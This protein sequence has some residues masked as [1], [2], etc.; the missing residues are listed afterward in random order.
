MD[1]FGL[2]LTLAQHLLL[3]PLFSL[4]WLNFLFD[5]VQEPPGG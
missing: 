3:E 4:P 5:I 1:E 2:D